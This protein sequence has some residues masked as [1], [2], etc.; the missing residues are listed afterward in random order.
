MK[1]A[2]LIVILLSLALTPSVFADSIDGRTDK[3]P[4]ERTAF[5]FQRGL[6]NVFG[7][8]AEVRATYKREKKV[9]PKW[10]PVTYVPRTFSHVLIRIASGTHDALFHPWV[11]PFTDDISP[12][13]EVYDLPEYPWQVEQE[14]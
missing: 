1:K 3:G 10:W 9:T 2:F 12:F 14:F 8:L 6:K 5:V 7:S 11:A 13:T 4:M